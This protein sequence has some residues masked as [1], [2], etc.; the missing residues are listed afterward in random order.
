MVLH[1]QEIKEEIAKMGR[2]YLRRDKRQAYEAYS[3][4]SAVLS[5]QLKRGELTQEQFERA[6]EILDDQYRNVR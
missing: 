5:E 3:S 1:L 2:K 6:H 4:Q